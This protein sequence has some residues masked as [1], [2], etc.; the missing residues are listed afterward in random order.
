[1]K[2]GSAERYCLATR[3]HDGP[4]SRYTS[5]CGENAV[6]IPHVE[7]LHRALACAVS[8]RR[9]RLI[10]DEIRYLRSYLDWSG[11]DLARHLGVTPGTVS[12]W[13]NGREAMGPVAERL[14]R[15]LVVVRADPTAQEP[16]WLA[17][18]HRTRCGPPGSNCT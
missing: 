11:A 10:P 6:V 12:R 13:E 16:S 8:T 17:R 4:Q 14:L 15:F 2:I 18:W 9:G 7:E 5:G 1:M 3:H